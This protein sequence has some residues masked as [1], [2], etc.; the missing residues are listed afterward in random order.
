MW[1]DVML[2]V[3]ICVA[4]LLTGCAFDSKRV[5][6]MNRSCPTDDQIRDAAIVA[7]QDTYK[8]SPSI[9][10][11]C[12][13]PNFTIRDGTACGARAAKGW[14][15]CSRNDVPLSVVRAMKAKIQGCATG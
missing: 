5:V 6:E 1:G 15:Y 4:L 14:V 2:R 12:P 10:G 3:S 13:C 7:S 11:T 9:I 8:K